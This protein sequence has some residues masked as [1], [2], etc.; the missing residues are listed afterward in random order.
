MN[1]QKKEEVF[2]SHYRT[3]CLVGLSATL[4]CFLAVMGCGKKGEVI[5][6]IGKHSIHTGEYEDYYA[7][8]VDLA[9]RMA[10]AD[11]KVIA[12]A[13][14]NPESPVS[15]A[16]VPERHYAGYRDSLMVAQVAEEEGF[17]DDPNVQRMLEQNRLQTIGQLYINAK[18]LQKVKI[19]EAAKVSACKELRKKEPQKM[20]SLSLDDC[21]EVAERLLRRRIVNQKGEEVLNEIRESIAIKRNQNLD[22]DDYLDNLAL[23]KRLRKKGGCS[24]VSAPSV[25][26]GAGAGKGKAK[27]A[28]PK[29]KGK[30]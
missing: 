1:L 26:K 8:S 18:L 29:K 25:N 3:Y 13:I 21:L 9:G 16:L 14:C 7:T 24:A 30:K 17:L 11:R 5:E 15:K 19:P 23:Y 28:S 6:T 27:A 4:I 2:I 12:R 20:A 22:Q 10:G